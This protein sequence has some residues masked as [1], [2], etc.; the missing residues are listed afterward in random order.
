MN[1]FEFLAWVV[2]GFIILSVASSAVMG[3]VFWRARSKSVKE[4]KNRNGRGF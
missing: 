4:F 3:V 1:G 2:G